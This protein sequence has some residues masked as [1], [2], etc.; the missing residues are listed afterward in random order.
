MKKNFI[1]SAA[2]AAAGLLVLSACAGAA[3]EAPAAPGGAEVA[4]LSGTVSIDGSSTVGPLSE[5]AAE[6]FMEDAVSGDVLVTVGT[7]GTGGGFEKFCV[8]ETD[9]SNAS[10]LIKDEEIAL[11]A[12]NDISYDYITVANDALAIVV[13]GE[14]PLQ[15]ITVEQAKAIWESGSTVMTWADSG[16]DV[17]ADFASRKI[18]LFG[19]GTDSGTFD[20]FTKE[21]NGEEGNIRTDYTDIGEDDNA[22]VTGV[23]GDVNGMAFIPLSY[24]IEAESRGDVKGLE[25]DGGAGCVAPSG[26][27]VVAGTYVPLGR[28][29]YTYGSDTALARPEVVAFFEYMINENQRIADASGFVALTDAQRTEQLAKIAALKKG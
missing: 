15:C 22:A 9:G 5:A 3:E 14:N 20:Y 23:K 27:N 29:L 17:P 2:L 10:R 13:N 11:C 19:P 21:I 24:F 4:A 12:A 8:G 6:L 16:V 26:D 28:A 25:I 7:S 18:A 1:A